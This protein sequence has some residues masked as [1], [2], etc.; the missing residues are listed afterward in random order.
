VECLSG[1]DRADPRRADYF[2]PFFAGFFGAGLVFA[3]GAAFGAGFTA[4]FGAGLTAFFTGAF[5]AALAAFFAGAFAFGAGFAFGA[6]F[7]GAGF[8]AAFAAF[9]GLP[10]TVAPSR[11]AAWPAARRAIGIRNGE[12]LT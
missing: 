5:G 11:T 1:A 4:F 3:F 12:Q 8:A 10:E 9:A 6:A 2:L 7:F